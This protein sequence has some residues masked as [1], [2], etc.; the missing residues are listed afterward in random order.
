MSLVLPSNAGSSAAP[1]GANDAAA[2]HVNKRE[3]ARMIGVS[4]PTL[5]A[6]IDRYGDDFPISRRG[7]NGVEWQFDGQAVIDFLRA[8]EAEQ[9][10]SRTARDELLAQLRLPLAEPDPPAGASA[11]VITVKDQLEAA[12]LREVLRKEAEAAGRLVDAAEVESRFTAVF[13]ALNREVH[14]LVRR[15]A[16]QQQWPDAV[17]RQVQ[18]DVEEMQERVVKDLDNEVETDVRQRALV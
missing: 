10:A 6:L 4:L 18:A 7:T 16:A 13:T 3:L 1:A 12:R 14:A 8:R 15:L 17:L 11:T 9:A 2:V 5:S